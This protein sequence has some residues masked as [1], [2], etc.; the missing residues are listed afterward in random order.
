MRKRPVS[1][2]CDGTRPSFLSLDSCPNTPAELTGMLS[3]EYYLH[4]FSKAQPDLNWD[5][6]AVRREVHDIMRFWL[7]KVS[8]QLS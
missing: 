8:V 4:L 1:V 7:D 6:P 5:N 3:Q 2:A